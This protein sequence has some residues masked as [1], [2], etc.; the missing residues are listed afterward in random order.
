MTVAAVPCVVLWLMGW[1]A[2]CPGCSAR[3]VCRSSL[4][5]GLR[6]N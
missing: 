1:E 2:G 5:T 4:R 3:M 6:W